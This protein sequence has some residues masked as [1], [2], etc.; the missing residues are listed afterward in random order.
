[1]IGAMSPMRM[2]RTHESRNGSGAI[3]LD[4]PKMIKIFM[5][6][7]PITLLNAISLFHFLAA[8]IEVASSGAL[9]PT[10]TIVSPII[11]SDSPKLVATVTAPSTRSLPP[12]RRANIPPPIHTNT[13]PREWL[14][15][16]SSSS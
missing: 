4:I 7:D 2:S 13:F 11:V 8:M 3:I 14:D 5:I 9:V 12:I 15:S 1:M 16:M 10:A 6:F